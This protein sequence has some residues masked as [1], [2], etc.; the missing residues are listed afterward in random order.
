MVPDSLPI[1]CLI[2]FGLLSCSF[3]PLNVY[4]FVASSSTL[5]AKGKQWVSEKTKGGGR[6]LTAQ[7]R[8]LLSLLQGCPWPWRLAPSSNPTPR[9]PRNEKICLP[10]APVLLRVTLRDHTSPLWWGW[11]DTPFLGGSRRPW[12]D[13]SP[14]EQKK[15]SMEKKSVTSTVPEAT[16]IFQ[17]PG[18]QMR[19]QGR[20]ESLFLHSSPLRVRDLIR[21]HGCPCYRMDFDPHLFGS[22]TC[23]TPWTLPSLP[24]ARKSQKIEAGPELRSKFLVQSSCPQ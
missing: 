24:R 10:I 14:L 5:R 6:L 15:S 2:P 16:C 8:K 17:E 3:L 11:P 12:Q 18:I 21:S 20:R 7:L 9:F 4:E 19:S 22:K 23:F 1:L 13:N